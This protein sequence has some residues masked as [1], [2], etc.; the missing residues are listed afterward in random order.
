MRYKLLGRSGLRVSELCL[1]TM[2]FGQ[3]VAWGADRKTSAAMYDAF[4]AAGGNFVD[5]ANIYTK[6]TSEKIVGELIHPHREEVVLA[7]KYTLNMRSGDP[8]G[9]GN[10]R[11]NMMQAVENSLRRLGTDY[12]D[13]YWLHAWDYLTPVEEVMRGLDDLVRSGKVLYVG[14]SDTPAWVVSQ[15]NVLADLRGWSRFVG[16]QIEYSLIERT[17]ERDLLPMARAHEMAV[18]PWG[19]IGGGVLTG[20]YSKSKRTESSTHRYDENSESVRLHDKNLAIGDEVVKIASEIGCSP[21]Q[22]AIN[23]IR[24]QPGII[25]PIIGV[26][27]VEQVKD[28]VGCLAHPLTDEH[29]Q[30]LHDVS[31]IELGFPHHLRERDYFKEILYG[32]T[33]DQIDNHRA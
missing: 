21:A 16:L 5:T 28:N 4:R 11:K 18:T 30:R 1:G 10:H 33:I 9:S 25:I 27:T 26:R 29:L 7:T 32:G 22:V 20:K 24:Q 31:K 17:V 12:I 2:T 14:V 8:N 3:E 19:I 15:A 13:L 6:G 23:W